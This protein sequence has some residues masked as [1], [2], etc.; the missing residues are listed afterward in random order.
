V[1]T[2]RRSLKE[3]EEKEA[4]GSGISQYTSRKASLDSISASAELTP[5]NL[6]KQKQLERCCPRIIRHCLRQMWNL[7]CEPGSLRK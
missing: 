3:R 4:A 7:R 1:E 5:R 2:E 6:L